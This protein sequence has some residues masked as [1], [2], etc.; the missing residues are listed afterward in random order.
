MRAATSLMAQTQ[1][2]LASGLAVAL[3]VALT[4][5]AAADDS[6]VATI[7]TETAQLLSMATPSSEPAV[8]PAM[9]EIA[10][11]RTAHLEQ[12]ARTAPSK[13]LD[14]A[15]TEADRARLP[16]LVRDEVESPVRISGELSLRIAD[17]QEAGHSEL[18]RM[19]VLPNQERVQLLFPG[20]SPALRSGTSLS[21]EGLRIGSIVV[22]TQHGPG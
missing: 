6:L 2:V 8:L 3:C 14:L 7:Q 16:A 5:D 18:R 17:D 1:A 19:L 20:G 10:R 22:V 11:V 12:L 15:M 4:T 9:V 13:A 21:V